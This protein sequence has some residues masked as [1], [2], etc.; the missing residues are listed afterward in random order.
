MNTKYQEYQFLLS[1]LCELK[2]KYKEHNNEA[3]SET[4]EHVRY[5][6]QALESR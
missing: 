3:L 4:I 1:V 2:D 6:I 5:K